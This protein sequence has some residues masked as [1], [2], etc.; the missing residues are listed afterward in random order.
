MPNSSPRSHNSPSRIGPDNIAP[1][2]RDMASS[3]NTL[4]EWHILQS[5]GSGVLGRLARCKP[6]GNEGAIRFNYDFANDNN[7]EFLETELRYVFSH[8]QVSADYGTQFPELQD[9]LTKLCDF[10]ETAVN[11][12]L[13]A[14]QNTGAK[15]RVPYPN[16]QALLHYLD[17]EAGEDQRCDLDLVHGPNPTIFKISQPLEVKK[18]LS[19]AESCNELI[20]QPRDSSS[21]NPGPSFPSSQAVPSIGPLREQGDQVLRALLAKFSRCTAT[22]EVLL[23]LAQLPE[24]AQP[25]SVVNMFLP[26]CSDLGPGRWQ[27]AQCLPFK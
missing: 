19:A 1:P 13:I 2:A 8:K 18:A 7:L 14:S 23:H 4:Y 21:G 26:Y 10:L 22:H 15:P 25:L 3:L 9:S 16:L 27:E 17:H 24:L 5:I 20:I 12:S 6:T 11:L